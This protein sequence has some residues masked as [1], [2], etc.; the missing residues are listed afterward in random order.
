[1]V[2]LNNDLEV[3]VV[4][5]AFA[6]L[7]GQELNSFRNE[8]LFAEDGGV[9]DALELRQLLADVLPTHSAV[10]GHHLTLETATG[11]HH[12]VANARELELK[13][14]GLKRIFLSLEDRTVDTN[15]RLQLEKSNRQL[16]D[17]AHAASHDLQE[18]LR[19]I[20]MYA[21]RLPVV[22]GADISATGQKYLDRISSAALRL[23]SRIE[24][25]LEL[26]RLGRAQPDRTSTNLGEPVERAAKDLSMAI[27]EAHASVEIDALPTVWVDPEQMRILFQ[28]LIQNALKF[29]KPGQAPEIKIYE[30]ISTDDSIV[31][32]VEDNGIGIDDA[33]AEKVFEPFQRLHTHAE[34]SGTGIGL[35]LCRS[36]MDH[37]HGKIFTESA[38]GARFVL[39]FPTATN[40]V[41]LDEN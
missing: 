4:N 38:P 31:V 25:I 23:R 37:H 18:P 17:F 40:T 36:I 15:L 3:L 20:T 27:D 30:R 9:L 35:T 14:Q 22:L 26:S 29:V 6:H 8:P 10:T 19:K 33:Y 32:V 12:F 41:A 2:V 11:T 24:A 1:M 21:E 7:L 39:E 13:G 28:N 16:E 34:Y 5:P